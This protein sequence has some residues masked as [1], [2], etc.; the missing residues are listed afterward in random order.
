MPR[1]LWQG[2]FQKLPHQ[3]CDV[4]IVGTGL[5][6]LYTALHLDPALDVLLVSKGSLSDSNSMYAQGGIAA[7]VAPG[8]SPARHYEDSWQAGCGLGDPAALQILV[9]EGPE[10]IRLL[11]SWGVPFDLDSRGQLAVGREAAHSQ[12]RVVH[13]HGDATGFHVTN[14]LAGRLAAMPRRTVLENTCLADFLTGPDGRVTGIL[15]LRSGSCGEFAVIEARQTIL[16]SGGIGGLFPRTTNAATVTGDGLAAAI[17]CGAAVKDLEFI[18]F[19]PTAL[20]NP[21]AQGRCFLI[22]EAVRGEGGILR[23][24]FGKPF[25]AR[26][27]PLADLAPRDVVSRAIFCQMLRDGTD[28]VWL[29]ITSHSREFLRSR[30]PTIYETCIRLGLDMA[31]QWLPVAPVQHYFMG[32]VST[33]L[34]GQSSR[35]GLWAVGEAACT[36]IYGANR[37]ASNSLLECLVFGRRAARAINGLASGLDPGAHFAGNRRIPEQPRLLARS[38]P[39]LSANRIQT[40]RQ[41]VRQLMDRHCGIMRTQEGLEL[42]L[43]QLEHLAEEVAGIA[44]SDRK[45]LETCQMVTSARAIVQAALQRKNSVGAH[46]RTDVSGT[47][48]SNAI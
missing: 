32:G 9:H 36:G 45:T 35:E 27:H 15:V 44:I 39:A 17:R 7:A 34:D 33:S 26:L 20:P 14:T 22:S 48:L 30:F 47:C 38:R 1:Y 4:V 37:L 40:I 41:Q 43:A 25:M 13:C 5:A 12:D 19:H 2:D 16:A 3:S 10:N 46:Y 42:A 24:H 21:D 11:Q 28:H 18:Q 31:S 6:G 8:D 23:N 29:D